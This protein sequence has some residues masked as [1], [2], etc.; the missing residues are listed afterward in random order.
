MATNENKQNNK[1]E[2]I[3]NNIGQLRVAIKLYC[4]DDRLIKKAMTHIDRLE[5]VFENNS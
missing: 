4:K 2:A 3:L 1:Y 5:S